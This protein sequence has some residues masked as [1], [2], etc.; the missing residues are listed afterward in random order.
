MKGGA[1]RSIMEIKDFSGGQ[2]TRPPEKGIDTK[3]SIDA[4]N[5]YSEGPKLR[6]RDGF[7]VVNPT[8]VSGQGNGLFNWVKSASLQQMMSVFGSVTY[9]M[10]TNS[11]WDGV[12]DTVSFDSANG[13]AFSNDIRH[14]VTYNGTLIMSSESRDKPQYMRINDTSHFNIE[15]LGA[16]TGPNGK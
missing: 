11:G 15:Y 3:Y 9:S 12:L 1:G 2:V 4:L 10:D 5:V 7:T 6:R 14:F 13:A 16:G 8:T